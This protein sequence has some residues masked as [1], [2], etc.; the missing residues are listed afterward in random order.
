MNRAALGLIVLATLGC[1]RPSAGLSC[2]VA[3]F[4]ASTATEAPSA[5]P[6]AAASAV[7]DEPAEGDGDASSPE[8]APAPPQVTKRAAA[9]LEAIR[10]K[11]MRALAELVHPERGVRFSAYSYVDIHD[12]RLTRA[13]VAAAM[14]DAT[15]RHW[16]DFDGSGEPIDLTF[17][18]Y[19]AHFVWDAD[20]TKGHARPADFGENTIDNAKDFYAPDGIVVEYYLDGRDPRFGGMDWR[21]LRLVMAPKDGDYYLVGVIHA[22]WTI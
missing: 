10:T 2:P 19:Q 20:F 21:A 5:L 13:Q 17:A 4:D 18:R 14:S 7:V 1:N 8:P 12:I 16:G 9:V 11:D 3:A 15:V 6:A 22:E